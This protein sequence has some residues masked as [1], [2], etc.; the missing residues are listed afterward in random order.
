MLAVVDGEPATSLRRGIDL[1]IALADPEA[2]A[3]G[4]HGVVRLAEIVGSDKSRVSRTLRTLAEY[5][6]VQR[7]PGT[8]AY[9]PG[10]R[11]FAL[12]QRSGDE[13]LRAAGTPFVQALVAE[14]DEA[15]HLSVLT[16][17][18]VLTIASRAPSHALSAAGLVGR[19]VP[20]S[21]TSSGRALLMDHDRPAL[22]RLL[23]PSALRAPG[24]NAPADLDELFARL[25]AARRR[26]FALVDEEWE[27][28][29]VG[30]AAP[31]RD[32]NG[33]IVA[34]LNLSAPKFR[35]AARLT[36]AGKRVRTAADELSRSLGWPGRQAA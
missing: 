26:G 19:T 21:C 1:L 2:L 35:F 31:V 23:P 5:D 9:R 32:H 12:A 36:A 13:H 28:G 20:A 27:V 14:F 4:G 29:L 33:H 18:V 8:L 7:D 17:S 25:Q 15:A 16:G 22:E 24:P 34:A 10:W 6:L 3:R 11:L 30:A